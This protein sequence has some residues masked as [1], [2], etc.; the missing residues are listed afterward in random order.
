[1]VRIP[2]AFAVEASA[3]D[4]ASVPDAHDVDDEYVV[5]HFI[6]DSVITHADAIHTVLTCQRDACGRAWFLG[7][8]FYRGS[9]ALLVAAFKRGQ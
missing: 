2:G 1:M 5:N 9:D 3:V 8:E 6:D 4:L 7:Q